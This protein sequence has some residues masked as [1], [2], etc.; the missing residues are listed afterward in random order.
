MSS[1]FRR[2]LDRHSVTRTDI[3]YYVALQSMPRGLYL[4]YS[5]CTGEPL[6]VANSS[7]VTHAP[8]SI[9]SVGQKQGSPDKFILGIPAASKQGSS[10]FSTSYPP[11]TQYDDIAVAS[12]TPSQIQQGDT[13]NVIIFGGP[14]V[15]TPLDT[16][17]VVK[18]DDATNA[19]ITDTDATISN[20]VWV[21]TEEVT[22]DIAVSASAPVGKTLSIQAE[23]S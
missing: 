11:S 9:V 6:V 2:F 7:G 18:W 4:V 22:M 12:A 13:E 20:V 3:D 15:E 16:F 19:W 21:S 10:A 1:R 23:R 14:F 5:V 8:G 17:T